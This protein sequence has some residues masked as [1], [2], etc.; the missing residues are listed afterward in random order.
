[1]KNSKQLYN[2]QYVIERLPYNSLWV[3]NKNYTK[4]QKNSDQTNFKWNF[5]FDVEN[6]LRPI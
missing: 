1:M 6:M 5:L 3:Y 4:I 2:N